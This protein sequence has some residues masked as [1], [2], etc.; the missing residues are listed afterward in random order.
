MIRWRQGVVSAVRHSWA[1]V[2]EL[3]VDTPD[4]SVRALAYTD[5]VGSPEP[6]QRVLLNS[7]ALQ[8]RLGTGGYA[9]VVAVPD[10]LP[11]DASDGPGHLVKARY[12]PLQTTVL[13]IDE[14][15]SPWHSVLGDAEDLAAL[16]V[17]VCDLHS[18][19]PAVITGIRRYRPDARVAYLMTDGG[20]LPLVFSRSVAGLVAAGW[21]AATITVGQAYGG[22]IEAV[23][24]HTG[25]LAARHVVAADVV[26]V[27]QG[28]GN[29]GTGTRWGFSGVAAAEALHAAYV[30]GGRPIASLRVSQADSRPRHYGVSHHSLTAYGRATLVPVEVVVPQLGGEL[31]T[32]V[33]D[34]VA[35]LASRHRLVTVP[36]DGLLD[37]L[38]ACPVSLSTMG[39]GLTEDTAAFLSSA[40]AGRHAAS[41]LGATT[42]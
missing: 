4:G 8:Q 42:Q 21:L 16:P 14:P 12:T 40:A 37:A 15:D 28:P 3:D 17:I 23:T 41:C 5:L 22:S 27:A 25:L 7:T 36:V 19:V 26:V 39:R 9:L 1:G 24:V 29:L 30:L 32:T 20:A 10:A 31:A 18:A 38:R 2:R 34:Q 35:P 33:R 11:P 6:G 13:G